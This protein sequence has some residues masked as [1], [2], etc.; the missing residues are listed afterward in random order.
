M[1][2]YNDYILWFLQ[3]GIHTRQP[4]LAL[5]GFWMIWL[6]EA[7]ITRWFESGDGIKTAHSNV[8]A[9]FFCFRGIELVFIFFYV[10]AMGMCWISPLWSLPL[11]GVF[12][13]NVLK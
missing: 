1:S 8:R 13:Y 2:L 10:F 12:F 11:V 9:A 4:W 3:E 6:I 5:W 7:G